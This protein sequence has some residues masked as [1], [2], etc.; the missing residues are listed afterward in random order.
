[1]KSLFTLKTEIANR[2]FKKIISELNKIHLDRND[3]YVKEIINHAADLLELVLKSKDP[4]NCW[5]EDFKDGKVDD[6]EIATEL[7]DS[8][9]KSKIGTRTIHFDEEK[10]FLKTV[11]LFFSIIQHFTPLYEYYKQSISTGV[12]IILE[13][14]LETISKVVIPIDMMWYDYYD[15]KTRTTSFVYKGWKFTVNTFNDVDSTLDIIDYMILWNTDKNNIDFEARTMPMLMTL[16]DIIEANLEP[17]TPV[18]MAARMNIDILS[19]I[20]YTP[21]EWDK[22]ILNSIYGKNC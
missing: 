12:P 13:D 6:Y 8:C 21:T 2:A 22:Q 14:N 11:S 17:P 16:D 4:N 20:K 7:H 9:V 15:N 18:M 5:V 1:M 3:E 19:I 10:E